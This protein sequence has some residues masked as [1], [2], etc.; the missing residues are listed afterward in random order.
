VNALITIKFTYLTKV[1]KGVS[2]G[3][4]VVKNVLKLDITVG[5]TKSMEHLQ[6][7]GQLD[8]NARDLLRRLT[9]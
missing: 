2:T 6:L 4:L 5:I 8:A 9:L 3:Q 7:V 1:V